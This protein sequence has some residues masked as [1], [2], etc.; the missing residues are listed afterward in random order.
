M[1]LSFFSRRCSLIT[2]NEFSPIPEESILSS[3]G[4]LP[5][6]EDESKLESH[7]Q[8]ELDDEDK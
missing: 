2:S 1:K 5:R 7:L 8:R 4:E 3:F 6:N